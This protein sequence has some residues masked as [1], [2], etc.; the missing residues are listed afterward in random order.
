MGGA[1]GVM[2]GLEQKIRRI[3]DCAR[4]VRF[5]GRVGGVVVGRMVANDM[6]QSLQASWSP[7]VAGSLPRTLEVCPSLDKVLYQKKLPR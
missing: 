5:A 3:V 6:P 1:V 7:D 4:Q 2:F